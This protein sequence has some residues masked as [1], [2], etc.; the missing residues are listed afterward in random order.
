[1]GRVICQAKKTGRVKHRGKPTI[2]WYID[3][4]PQYYCYGYYD[5]ATDMPLDVCQK[6]ADFV[7]KAD[8]DYFKVLNERCIGMEH[9]CGFKKRWC[10]YA[11]SNGHCAIT[12]CIKAGE[13]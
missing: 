2:E 6:C 4:K 12:A 8:D 1:M 10:E 13:E 9:W 3:G 7:D 11:N 5:K